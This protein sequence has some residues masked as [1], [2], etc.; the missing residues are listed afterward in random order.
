MTPRCTYASWLGPDA[1]SRVSGV[2]LPHPSL[3]PMVPPGKGHV[4]V[5]PAAP[6]GLTSTMQRLRCRSHAQGRSTHQHVHVHVCPLQ[7]QGTGGSLV[8]TLRQRPTKAN[9]HP[10]PPSC[11][12]PA[13]P[14]HTPAHVGLG[15]PST[16]TSGTRARPPASTKRATRFEPK[17]RITTA[18]NGHPPGTATSMRPATRTRGHRPGASARCSGWR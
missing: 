11:A 6:A 4:R 12:C 16:G 8:G 1:W 7:S 17:Q 15:R 2:A 10:C 14:A 9:L 13:L 18:Q 5:F 3:G